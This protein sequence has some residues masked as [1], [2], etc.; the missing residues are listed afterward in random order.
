MDSITAPELKALLDAGQP[1]QLLDVRTP[2]EWNYCRLPG[3]I[4]IP[5][6]ELPHRLAELDPAAEIVVHCHHGI[7]SQRAIHFLQQHGFTRL[8]NLTGGI[9]AWSMLVDPSLPRY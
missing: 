6:P 5:L 8:K 7:R 9:D 2:G 4:L 3:A 1:L